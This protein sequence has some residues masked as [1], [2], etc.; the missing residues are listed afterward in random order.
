MTLKYNTENDNAA[1][2]HIKEYKN[3]SG[4]STIATSSSISCLSCLYLIPA[5]SSLLFSA[6][7]KQIFEHGRKKTF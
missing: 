7:Y 5:I 2:Q 4:Y 1:D 3:F 6:T